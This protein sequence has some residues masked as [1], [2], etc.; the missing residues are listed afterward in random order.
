MVSASK[1]CELLSDRNRNYG[2]YQEGFE[3]L[4]MLL[5][6]LQD[7]KL[8]VDSMRVSLKANQDFFT[9]CGAVDAED[10]QRHYQRTEDRQ[11]IYKGAFNDSRPCK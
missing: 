6:R 1:T 5:S 11:G 8:E 3:V 4:V 2:L 7:P 9:C 10:S